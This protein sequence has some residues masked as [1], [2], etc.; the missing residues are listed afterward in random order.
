MRDDLGSRHL[1]FERRGPIAWCIIDRPKARNALTSAMYFGLRKAVERVN[2]DPALRALV[3]TGVDDVFA[4]GGEMGGRHDDDTAGVGELLGT[5]VLPFH[6]LRH[7]A[8]PVVA[9]VNGICQGGG[10]MLAMLAD[11]AVAS[12]RASFRA[13]ELL[14]GV[15][16]AWFAAVLPE[17]VG[18]ARA[19]ELMFTGRRID[20]AE[21]LR[22]GL[23]ARVVPHDQLQDAARQLVR[24][25]L[26]TAPTA[27]AQWKR[28]VNARYGW[29]DEPGFEA[30]LR[31]DECLEGFRAFV[32][33]RPPSW[34][35]EED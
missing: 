5:G 21:A 7:S 9:A 11:V 30:S 2:S 16:D 17:Q 33:K 34:V 23:V 12:E 22:I 1:R 35:P 26:Q 6:A 3:L 8:A 27:R 31:G 4:P 28:M 13:P 24:E 18:I 25:I 19:R 14:R 15:A 29:V 20:A 10:L 32:E